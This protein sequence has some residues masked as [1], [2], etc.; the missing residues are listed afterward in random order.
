MKRLLCCITLILALICLLASCSNDDPNITINEDGYVVVNGIKTE[1]KVNQELE[2][3][4][5]IFGENGICNICSAVDPN[6]I[7]YSVNLGTKIDTLSVSE[8]EM[9]DAYVADCKTLYKFGYAATALDT[10]LDLV[11]YISFAD[12]LVYDFRDVDENTLDSK[13]LVLWN[14]L[15]K[16]Y[17]ESRPM[18]YIELA[19]YHTY[20]NSDIP[21]PIQSGSIIY[22]FFIFED[23]TVISQTYNHLCRNAYVYKLIEGT[24]FINCG[25]K[26]TESFNE[27]QFNAW[28]NSTHEIGSLQDLLKK[29]RVDE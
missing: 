11:P 16:Y 26:Y 28:V 10:S 25:D 12:V 21:T 15:K 2:G 23:D 13:S 19:G 9:I 5:H 1:Y 6:R 8:Q 17:I 29:L 7:E 22:G 24:K 18:I 20:F 14:N 3:C 27:E 4:A